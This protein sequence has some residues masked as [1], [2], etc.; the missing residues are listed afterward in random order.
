L[1]L[2]V[3]AGDILT[4]DTASERTILEVQQVVPGNRLVVSP[5][6]LLTDS[7]ASYDVTR[8]IESVYLSPEFDLYFANGTGSIAVNRTK[9]WFETENFTSPV[10]LFND[11]IVRGSVAKLAARV[12]SINDMDKLAGRLYVATSLGIFSVS[13]SDLNQERGVAFLYSTSAVTEAEAEYKILEGTD[14]SAVAVAVDP[15]TGNVSV[16]VTG[17]SSVVTEINP[18]IQQAFRFYDNVGRVMSLVAYRNPSGPP[19]EVP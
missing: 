6:L 13:D 5:E 3:Q 11:L 2:R 10:P 12:D 16:A 9:D 7:G 4:P 17:A 18:T 8:N 15:E 14:K 1:G 19:D